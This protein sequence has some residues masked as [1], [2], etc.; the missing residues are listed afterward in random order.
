MVH[1]ALSA[2]CDALQ[3]SVAVIDD[4]GRIVGVN[5]AWRTFGRH[6]GLAVPDAG[7][8]AN[9]LDVCDQARGADQP[10]ARAAGA[11]IR[12]L[13]AGTTR[14]FELEY[15]CHAPHQH[16]WFLLRAGRFVE[17]GRTYVL[18][19]HED[20]TDRRQSSAERET[21]L[22]FLHLVNARTGLRDLVAASTRFFRSQSGCEAVGIRL[23]DGDDFPYYE[24]L[25]FPDA[26]VR[27][28][29]SLCSRL[30]DGQVERDTVGSPVLAC[31][32]GNV[33]CGRFD[34]A[35]PFFTAAGSFWTNST[36]ELL[37]ST[38]EADRQARTRNRCHGEGYESVALL[39]LRLGDERLGLLQLND[40]RR[41]VFTP[42]RIAFWER[43]VGY[44]A[45]AL[46]HARAEEALRESE[47]LLRASQHAAGLGSYVLDI[48]SGRWRSSETLDRLFGIGRH[49]D[50]SVE[51]WLAIVHPDDRA[52][53]RRYV[54]E[55]IRA[56]AGA[57]D[58]EYRI[59]RQDDR[60]EHWVHGLGRLEAD[61]RGHGLTLSGTVHDVTARKLAESTLRASEAKYRVLA[62]SVRDVVWTLDA[63]TLRYLY[64]SPSVERLRGFTPEEIMA[65]PLEQT[66]T[67][68][69]APGLMAFV[70]QTVADYRSGKVPADQS[71]TLEIEQPCK[72]GS[73]VWTEV[74][75][76]AH[77]N[78]ASGRLEVH[79]VSRDISDRKRSEA[80]A[81]RH[82]AAV[83]HLARLNTM[84]Q[85]ATGLAH[86]I[87]Q[88]LTA[89]RNYAHYCRTAVQTGQDLGATLPDALDNLDHA[90][91]RAAQIVQR[92]R[93]FVRKQQAE[94]TPTDLNQVVR[95][96]SG[97]L[98][99]ALR[100][101]RIRVVQQLEPDL[102]KVT[103]DPVQIEQVLVNLIQNAVDAMD[104][105]PAAQRVI[106]LSTRVE[107]AA[108]TVHV[109]VADRGCGIA[110]DQAVRIFEEFFTTR[111]D[112]LG[113][114]LAISKDI[115]ERHGGRMAARANPGGGTVLEVI[116]P[117]GR[118]G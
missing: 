78:N 79:G 86:E 2:M 87:N 54:D 5:E 88:P 33:V 18:L 38:T 85:I 93:G 46:A 71:Y 77:L 58:R 61:A 66:F 102:P 83:A 103:V 28:E 35:L 11:G 100:H 15:P 63:Q 82:Q 55:L 104:S 68:R 73:T 108:G 116:L 80:E 19:T 96:S 32:C 53:M 92:L 101:G 12:G 48:A 51:G 65:G 111:P 74:V 41:N 7:V 72:D 90:A 36:T 37:A 1:Q 21:A 117:I 25:G 42:E 106:V 56:R 107:G 62:E 109:E 27:S 94:R 76:G 26:F 118:E 24:T 13:L 16:R 43:L 70:R 29:N 112:G 47:S 3:D 64:V 98:G 50:R 67:P 75:A 60:T 23:R 8:G 97:L 115:V 40:R 95:E 20:I 114:G 30:P 17:A 99:M 4:T 59:I 9:Y 6:N 44:L 84:G 10:L 110:P 39:P 45:V 34:P 31:M 57:F 81:A 91:T 52:A 22:A 69:S 105:V 89:I 14:S 113:L 49:Y